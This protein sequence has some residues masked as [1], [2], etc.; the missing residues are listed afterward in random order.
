MN[1]LGPRLADD[2]YGSL[3]HALTLVDPSKEAIEFGVASG[4]TIRMI[5]AV[6]S[7]TGFDSFEGLPEDWRPGFE[8]G[9]FAQD[10]PDVG[11]AHLVVGLFDDTLPGWV[12][13]N[14]SVVENLGLIHIDCD[15]YSS[16]V[17]ILRE[18]AEWIKPGVIIVFDE[19]HGY[20]GWEE[21]EYR[22]GKNSSP[23]TR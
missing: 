2:Y 15:L 22:L 19:F 10:I 14:K 21:H 7:V 16:T 1:D 18:L 4:L 8:K 11:G 3:A 6:M 20:P 23:F 17:T 12:A 5:D 13:E 9:R